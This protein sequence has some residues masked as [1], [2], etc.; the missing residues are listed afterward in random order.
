MHT[1]DIYQTSHVNYAK[2]MTFK[3]EN[4]VACGGVER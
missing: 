2:T 4:Q 3:F 1:S